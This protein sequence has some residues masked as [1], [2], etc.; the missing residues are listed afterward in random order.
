MVLVKVLGQIV[1]SLN[2]VNPKVIA[3]FL[4]F[5]SILSS[6]LYI[7]S[8]DKPLHT[9]RVQIR[10]VNKFDTYFSF[11]Y[12]LLYLLLLHFFFF[13][14]FSSSSLFFF[15][16]FS[17]FFFFFSS[18]SSS[19]SFF[20]FFFFSSL[21][22]HLL[23]GWQLSIWI[24]CKPFFPLLYNCQLLCFWRL[25]LS[26]AVQ[27]FPLT[28]FQISLLQVCLLQTRYVQLFALS[29]SDVYFLKFLKLIFLHSRLKNFTIRY[30]LCPFYF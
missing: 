14:F 19:S 2:V 6:K 22:P 13:F 10:T 28:F 18:S 27:V 26:I 30:S 15:S 20:F 9:I 11:F 17:S 29:M 25:A 23:I 12:L 8:S 4:W 16:F 21:S 5:I 7:I 1:A 24:C 3:Y